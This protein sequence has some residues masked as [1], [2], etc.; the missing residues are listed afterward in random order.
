MNLKM[1]PVLLASCLV[2]LSAC[3][4]PAPEIGWFHER[5]QDFAG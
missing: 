3:R 1:H 5:S 2:L 4:R